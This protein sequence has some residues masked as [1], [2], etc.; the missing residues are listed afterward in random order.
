MGVFAKNLRNLLLQPP[1]RGRRVLAVDPGFKSGCKLA[2]LDQFG[3]MLAQDVIYLIGKPERREE[4]RSKVLDL[5]RRF[6][7]SGDRHRQRHRL[8]PERGLL[9]RIGRQRAQGAGRRLRDRQR[10]RGQRLFDQPV[11]PRG[12]SQLRRHAPRRHFDRPPLAGPLE[13]AGQDRPGEHRRRA[14][15]STTSRPSI[16]ARRWTKWSNRAST[17]WA[18]T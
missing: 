7:L 1:V 6:E 15:I 9:R 2:A 11:G 13:R 17:T 3:N 8:P 16:F 10:G 12:I 5:V 4:A 18:W 14:C